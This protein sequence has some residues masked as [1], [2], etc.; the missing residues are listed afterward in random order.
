MSENSPDPTKEQNKLIPIDHDNEPFCTE[1]PIDDIMTDEKYEDFRCFTIVKVDE[2][3]RTLRIDKAS[4][5]DIWMKEGDGRGWMQRTSE[6]RW[7]VR[8]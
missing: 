6:S 5:R 8:L 1:V 3:S 4:G 2:L 7:T